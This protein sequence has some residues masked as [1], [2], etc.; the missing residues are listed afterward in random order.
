MNHYKEM[1]SNIYA[2]ELMIYVILWCIDAYRF[3]SSVYNRALYGTIAH[4]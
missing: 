2:T 4:F 3:L 1:Q